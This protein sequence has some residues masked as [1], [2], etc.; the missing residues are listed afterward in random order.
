MFGIMGEFTW[1][2]VYVGAQI[3]LVWLVGQV[4]LEALEKR[5]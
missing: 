3:A 1:W 5:E 2:I 4:V